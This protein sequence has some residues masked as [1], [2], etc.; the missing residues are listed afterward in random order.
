MSRKDNADFIS[1]S[2][3]CFITKN[4]IE[5]NGHSAFNNKEIVS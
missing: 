1:F 5:E 2:D 3:N 4:S